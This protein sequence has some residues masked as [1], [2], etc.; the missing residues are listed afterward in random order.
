MFK[1][2]WRRVLFRDACVLLIGTTFIVGT[3]FTGNELLPPKCNA[4]VQGLLSS[5]AT[6]ISTIAFVEVLRWTGWRLRG[7]ALDGGE[8]SQVDGD[9]SPTSTEESGASSTI[10]TLKLN[11]YYWKFAIAVALI[12][13]SINL[14]PP[15]PCELV[16]LESSSIKVLVGNLAFVCGFLLMLKANALEN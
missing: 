9:A 4:S 1:Y 6:L 13:I 10:R 8:Q 11:S 16:H 3:G 7:Q 12:L 14:G 5:L 15:N 2:N